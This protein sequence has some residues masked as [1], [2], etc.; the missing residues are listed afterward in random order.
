MMFVKMPECTVFWQIISDL[1]F[2][3]LIF[4]V[5]DYILGIS[6][7]ASFALESDINRKKK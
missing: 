3:P 7:E 1:R 5:F 4:P 6:H 2:P